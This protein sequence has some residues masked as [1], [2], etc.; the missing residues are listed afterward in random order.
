MLERI[1]ASLPSLAPA[2]QRVGKLVLLDPRSF[3][4]LPVSEL[5]DRSHVSKPTVV[6]FCRIMGYDGLFRRRLTRTQRIDRAQAVLATITR[7][8]LNLDQLV[9]TVPLPQQQLIVI[10]RALMH[11]PS[12]LILYEATAALDI[13]D[14]DLLFAAIKAFVARERLVIY[15]SHRMDE[16]LDLSDT[17]TVLRSGQAVASLPRAEVSVARLLKLVLPDTP[18]AETEGKHAHA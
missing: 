2:E 8:P 9:E 7:V 16:V 5:A 14:R 3:A 1:K 17:V 10:A 11:D 13:E 12:I 15:I 6:R 18:L 4:S